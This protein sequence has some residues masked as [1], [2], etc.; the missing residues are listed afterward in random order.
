MLARCRLCPRVC[1][2]DRLHGSLGECRT[3]ERAIVSSA[4]LHFGEE[5]PLVGL[6]GSGTI[7][8]SQ[9]NLRCIFCQNHDISHG[10]GGRE[11][12]ARELASLM[13]K[14]QR[15][16]A[17]N[18]NLVSPSHV[19]P[20]ILEA[21]AIAA[22]AGLQLPIVYNSGGYDALPALRLLDGVIDLYMPDAK[23]DDAAIGLSLSG[24]A[25][26][27]K[28]NRS[29]LREMHRQVGDLVVDSRGVAVRGLI[30]RHL[31]LP[32]G[33]AGTRGIMGFLASLSPDTYVNVMDQ[34]RPCHRAS[35][36]PRLRRGVTQAEYRQAFELAR[37]AG[38]HRF[39]D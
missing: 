4:H 35:E 14:L 32:E 39:A 34:Y 18:I 5:A 21:V 11:V 19:V 10:G 23:Y 29:T 28:V 24:V 15:S 12:T 9:C 36:D 13:L 25:H 8:F 38:L 37:A 16:G 33:L 26:Y 17:Y 1:A 30:V 31:V 7:F 3:G 27:P 20:Q 22:E 6:G 2:V